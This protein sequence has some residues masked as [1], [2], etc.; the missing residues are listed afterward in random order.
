MTTHYDVMGVR[1]HAPLPEI[2][3]AYYRKARAY[4][5]DAHAGST[6]PVLH[7]A[8]RAMAALN[9]AW[10]VLRDERLRS[11]YDEALERAEAA[12]QQVGGRRPRPTRRRQAAPPL[13]I[14]SGF[15]YW[16]GSVSG[17][18]PDEDGMPRCNLSVEKGADLAALRH[19][20]P[21]GLWGLHCEGS[22]VDDTQLAHLHGMN[23]LRILDLA[24]TDVS[25]AGLVHI[26]GLDRLE[27]LSLWDTGVTDGGMGLVG[28][29]AGLRQLGLGRTRITDAGL[30]HLGT[31]VQLNVLQLWG[32]DVEGPGLA[33]LHGLVDLEIL[34]LPRGVPARF[35]RR[36][37]RALP[38][39]L[40]Q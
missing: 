7:E 5:P 33:H 28:R 24:G 15:R 8:S 12:L 27:T 21:N 23:G 14:G 25:D 26:Q 9:A 40:I 2:K 10:N 19:L 16:L 36:L 13:M 39:T 30:A 11:E 38:H 1:P 31:L 6:T 37:R 20:A 4:H 18:L 29:L 34:T 35:R 32:T 3:R 22:T 17:S